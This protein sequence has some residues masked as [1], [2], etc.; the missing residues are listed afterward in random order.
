MGGP[1]DASQH[2]KEK[3][4]LKAL[5]NQSFKMQVKKVCGANERGLAFPKGTFGWNNF[6]LIRPLCLSCLNNKLYFSF[7][8]WTVVYL[9]VY[10]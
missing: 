3:K 2:P 4:K 8:L 6:C 5:T 7:V 1:K 9:C 10:I